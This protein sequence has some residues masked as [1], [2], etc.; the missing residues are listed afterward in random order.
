M[1][2]HCKL[3]DNQAIVSYKFS[4]TASETIIIKNV[5]IDVRTYQRT[6]NGSENYREEGFTVRFYSPNNRKWIEKPI[7]DYVLYKFDK[8]DGTLGDGISIMDCDKTDFDR[9]LNGNIS[10]V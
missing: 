5:P 1:T 6:A 9:D 8:G 4:N 10:G 2:T 3:G 7:R